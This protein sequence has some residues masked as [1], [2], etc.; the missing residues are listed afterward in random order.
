MRIHRC[1]HE[2]VVLSSEKDFCLK[3]EKSQFLRSDV[4]LT[5]DTG[6]QKYWYGSMSDVKI[7][8]NVSYR[9]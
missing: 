6:R 7:D 4:S 3:S 2:E 1:I 5:E 9:C 8:K